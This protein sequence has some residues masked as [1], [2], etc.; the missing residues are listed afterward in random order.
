MLFDL[1]GDGVL[2]KRFA[3]HDPYVAVP[4]T[5]ILFRVLWKLGLFYLC[6]ALTLWFCRRGARQREGGLIFGTALACTGFFAIVLF[7]P[8]TQSR[9]TSLL[10]FFFLALALALLARPGAQAAR[11]AIG[12]A[13]L[14]AAIL[15][16][17]SFTFAD[18][19]SLAITGRFEQILN[20][21]RSGDVAV[22]ITSFDDVYFV[23][24]QCLLYPS[25]G[26]AGMA[27]AQLVSPA[28]RG[29]ANWRSAFAGRVAEAWSTGHSVWIP[30]RL[31]MDA[32]APSWNWTEG[33]NP[34]LHWSDFPAFFRPFV[35]D[36]DIGGADGFVRLAHNPVNTT[37]LQ[38]A[39]P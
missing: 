4:I 31:L 10:P 12:A 35:F 16:V 34:V 2:L 5:D 39:F 36:S 22:A 28:S 33:D 3:F 8:S 7:E 11:V 26:S 15:N 17:W 29:A 21:T 19:C 13:P 14:A 24:D 20:A 18:R 27:I 32:P 9:F 6:M 37:L 1:S 30:K 25:D 23:A 38:R